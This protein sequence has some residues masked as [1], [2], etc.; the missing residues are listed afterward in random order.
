[1]AERAFAQLGVAVGG[2]GI[3][4]PVQRLEHPVL[5]AAVALHRRDPGLQPMR[6]QA[7]LAGQGQQLVVDRGGRRARR[8]LGRLLGLRRFL[9]GHRLGHRRRR[10]RRHRREGRRGCRAVLQR[11]QRRQRA[12]E[13]RAVLAGGRGV[14]RGQARQQIDA[15]QQDVD[16]GAVERDM[17]ALGR[18]EHVFHR[19]R[20]A[21]R[22][23]QRDD[24]GGALDR[25]GRAHQRVQRGGVVLAAFQAQQ[26]VGQHACAFL[27]LHAE[28]VEHRVLAQVAHQVVVVQAHRSNPVKRSASRAPSGRHAFARLLVLAAAVRQAVQRRQRRHRGHHLHRRR[29]PLGADAKQHRARVGRGLRRKRARQLARPGRAVVRLDR[30]Q[31]VALRR[32][33][34]GR[35]V[36]T[37]DVAGQRGAAAV[38][39]HADAAPAVAG[40]QGIDD[41]LRHAG[42]PLRR[43]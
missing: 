5:L 1:V 22:R 35:T 17:A 13:P 15:G 7:R 25:V 43:R 9:R 36:A 20:Q 40:V 24:R 3:E 6:M 32:L 28:Q 8:L 2:D 26:A 4:Q 16:R 31:Q 11:V 33:G 38:A 42:P 19:M 14:G 12:L 30:A 37:M 21:H 41:R 34:K 29:Q 18:H 23:R 10:R 27:R 39:R